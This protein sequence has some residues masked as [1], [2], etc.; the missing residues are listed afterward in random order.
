MV[1]VLERVGLTEDFLTSGLEVARVML[2]LF[3]DAEPGDEM[4]ERFSFIAADALPTFQAVVRRAD[5]GGLAALAEDDRTLLMS[6]PF[7]LIAAR[8]RL[9]L[10]GER[11]EERLL[12]AR[13]QFAAGLPADL[14]GAVAFFE[15]ERYNP[16]ASVQDNILFGRLV[17]GRQQSKRLIG[18]LIDEVIDGL[19]L[20]PA[21]IGLGLEHPVGLAGSR[22]S[23]VQRQKV[24]IARGL[25]KRADLIVVDRATAPL[26]PATQAA[27]LVNVLGDAGPSGV[28]WVLGEAD[29]EGGFDHLYVMEHGRIVV[30]H[31]RRADR[32][33]PPRQR[34]AQAGS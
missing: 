16:A 27:I 29:D 21:I 22:L 26:D 8:H 13:R 20:R 30:H 23:A 9:G 10:V 31:D 19:G 25:L 4:F 1:A 11:A 28:V 34:E 5:V 7:K 24:V 3:G 14:T 17:Y 33:P 15:P 32:E 6:L 18:G 12:E 2:E